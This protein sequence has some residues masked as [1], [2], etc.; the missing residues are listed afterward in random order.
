MLALVRH[1]TIAEV[2]RLRTADGL[3]VSRGEQVVAR[4]HRGVQLGMVLDVKST[5]DDGDEA[6][7][8]GIL[9]RATADDI[10][11]QT[12]LMQSSHD[13][14]LA[15]NERI[16]GWGLD[17]Q[18]VD[19]EWTL[20][21]EKLILYVLNERGPECT[22]LALNAAASGLGVVEVQPVNSDGPLQLEGGG[23]CGSGGCGC[24]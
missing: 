12:A 7:E 11:Q 2:S 18:L 9:R 17:L 1:G 22:R 3:H 19:I 6:S 14:F 10:R 21:R 16:A 8:A 4:T 15:W 5:E 24:H 23:G 13:E 20:D